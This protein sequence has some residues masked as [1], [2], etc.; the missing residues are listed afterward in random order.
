M[1]TDDGRILLRQ[2]WLG[3]LAMCPERARQDMLG[4]AENT[5]STSTMIGTSVHYGIEQCLNEV[6]MTGEP[7][8]QAD[9]VQASM[10]WWNDSHDEIVRW[11]HDK[12]ECEDIIQKNTNVW[13]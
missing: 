1:I 4:I 11:N 7:L 10:Q 3:S 6:M 9:T 12:S 5:E 8:S 13:W 2:S